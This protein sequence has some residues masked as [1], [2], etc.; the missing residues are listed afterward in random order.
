M[1]DKNL[2]DYFNYDAISIDKIKNSLKRNEAFIGYFVTPQK[3]FVLDIT[4]KNTRFHSLDI[5]ESYLSSTIKKL[6]SSLDLNQIVF[7]DDLKKFDSALSYDLYRKILHPILK[8]YEK[9]QID[10][11]IF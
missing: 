6:R 5:N 7:I 9:H 11:L 4:K 10:H 2:F 3:L 1:E 8:G